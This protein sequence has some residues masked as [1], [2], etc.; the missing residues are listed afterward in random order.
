MAITGDIVFFYSSK[1]L[2]CIGALSLYDSKSEFETG[3]QTC[4]KIWSDFF[5]E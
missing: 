3:N 1:N 2:N 4:E 5:A